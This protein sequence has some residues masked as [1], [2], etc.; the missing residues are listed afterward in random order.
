M[1]VKNM[2]TAKTTD[3]YNLTKHSSIYFYFT[4]LSHSYQ[5]VSSLCDCLTEVVTPQTM[6]P[7]QVAHSGVS[8]ASTAKSRTFSQI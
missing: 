6:L 4:L 7:F 2:C 5:K 3:L 1:Y 8:F